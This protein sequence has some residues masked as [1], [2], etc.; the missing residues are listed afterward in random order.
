MLITLHAVGL[1]C[2]ENLNFCSFSL[3]RSLNQSRFVCVTWG[4]G[5]G[6]GEGGGRP[7]YCWY[8]LPVA[9]T[10]LQLKTECVLEVRRHQIPG[11]GDDRWGA[12]LHCY[13]S[14]RQCGYM[15]CFL[16][17]SNGSQFTRTG[18]EQRKFIFQ[19]DAQQK[20]NNG[21]IIDLQTTATHTLSMG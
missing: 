11:W 12:S 5:V 3:R 15:P 18:K 13:W 7:E 10:P 6:G 2:N 21:K 9:L 17:P 16:K 20:D 19:N 4:K 8:F 14:N 1:S